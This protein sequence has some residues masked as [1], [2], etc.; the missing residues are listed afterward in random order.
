M[1]GYYHKIFL[2]VLGMLA[3]G[4]IIIMMNNGALVEVGGF[5]LDL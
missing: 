4:T 2:Y 3:I 1:K 5:D